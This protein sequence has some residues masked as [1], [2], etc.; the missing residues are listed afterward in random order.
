MARNRRSA[1]RTAVRAVVQEY[2][3]AE[4][5]EDADRIL[6]LWRA[7]AAD[8]PTR[9]VLAT[10]FAAG[11]DRYTITIPAVRVTAG[12]A[13]ARVSAD[14]ERTVL[15]NGAPVVIRSTALTAFDLVRESDGWKIASERPLSEEIAD[16]LLAASPIERERMLADPENITVSVLHA[17]ENRGSRLAMGQQY[18]AAQG[19]LEIALAA[20]R[21]AHDRQSE[22]ATLQNLANA[23]YFQRDFDKAAAYYQQRLG[24]ARETQD[25]AD[26]VSALLGIATTHYARGDYTLALVS[27]RE[28][29]SMFERLGPPASMASTLISVGNVQ[30]MQAEYS[31]ATGSYRRAL[32]LLQGS[33]DSGAISMARSGLGR[34]F[35]AQGDLA[36]ALQ[37]YTTV[38]EDARA[39][40]GANGI[41]GKDIAATLESI[42]ELQFRLGNVDQARSAF[43]EARQSSD[44]RHDLVTAGRLLG[45]LG[46]DRAP[47]RQVRRGLGGLCGE[48]GAVR[49]R[50]SAGW[51]RACVGRRGIQPCGTRK[52]HGSCRRL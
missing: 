50:A 46:S 21:A 41:Q 20:A 51:R 10:L 23:L 12:E 18:S 39:Q 19:V 34:V 31:A 37:M 22:S 13:K 35:T 33:A 30:F 11:D 36:A 40:S 52:I 47:R 9:A 43:D 32:T 7:T 4:E 15:H 6:A 8:R 26:V 29:L 5:R 45:N 2:F 16:E 49:S 3:A 27:Y 24:L 38:L 28:A 17:L 44:A 25:E 14:R 42:G 1:T 48:P